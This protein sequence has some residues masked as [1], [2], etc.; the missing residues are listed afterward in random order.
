MSEMIILIP[1][2]HQRYT[3]R[4]LRQLD[5]KGVCA[6]CGTVKIRE[7]GYWRYFHG[8]EYPGYPPPPCRKHDWRRY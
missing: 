4:F 5:A 3:E 6:V 1:H 2:V 8:G 7:H